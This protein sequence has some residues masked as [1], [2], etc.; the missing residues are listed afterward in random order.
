MR[1]MMGRMSSLGFLDI[2]YLGAECACG[3]GVMTRGSRHTVRSTK[4]ANYSSRWIMGIVLLILN[5]IK[6]KQSKTKL[7]HSCNHRGPGGEGC[8]SEQNCHFSCW[9]WGSLWLAPTLPHTVRMRHRVLGLRLQ[10]NC[11][12][13][14][15][16]SVVI[17]IGSHVLQT[18]KQSFHGEYAFSE[19]LSLLAEEPK[20]ETATPKF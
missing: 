15:V 9:G 1:L 7:Y 10:L 11:D 5:V 17:Q 12:L 3:S 19:V 16:H 18:R 13:W 8:K 20:P 2:I 6:T 4:W 14:Q